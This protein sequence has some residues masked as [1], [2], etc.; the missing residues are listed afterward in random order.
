MK[1][2]FLMA[3]CALCSTGIWADTAVLSWNMGADGAAASGANSITG[4]AGCDAEGFT[5]A[6]TGNTGKN[7]SNGNGSISYNGK[8]Y[9][10]LKNSNGAQNTITLP[11]G[12]Y[13]SKVEFHVVSNADASGVLSE[14][15]GASCSDVV[16]SL[17]DYANP[18]LISKTLS[19]PVNSFTFTFSTKQV[20][21]IAV[22]TYSGSVTPTCANPTIQFGSWDKTENGFPVTITNNEQG[23]TLTYA[24][25]EGEFQAYTTSFFVGSEVV[26]KA[27][28]SKAD[29]NDSEVVTATAPAHAEGD[30]EATFAWLVGNE[31]S[32]TITS[33]KADCVNKTKVSTGSGLTVDTKSDYAANNGNTM[34]TYVPA[35]SNAGN[36][37][38]VMIEYSIA[39]AKGTT[40]QL[41]A[42]KYDALKDG[43][44][45]ASFSWSYT[46]DG[47]ESD[48]AVVS[49]DDLLR[50]NNVSGT[51]ALR[52]EE[53][54]T[55]AAGKNVTVRFY[56]SGFGNTKKFALSNIE[57]VGTI[58]GEPVLRTFQDFKIEFRDNPY[59]VILPESGTLP[60][61][62]EV[63]GTTYNGG[64][65]GIQGG[66]ITVPVDGA[67]LF[68][69]G[70]C[71]FSKDVI[72]VKKD[73]E[74]FTTISNNA[75]CGEQKP[76][77]NQF[78]TWKYNSE[79]AATLTFSIPG[80]VYIPYFFAEKAEYVAQVEVTYYDADGHTIIGKQNIE[81]GAALAFAYTA[82]D[83]TV[84]EGQ[85]FRGWFSSTEL[86]A[87]KIKAGTKVN[88][89]L[90]LYA[91][92]TDI[93]V[94]TVGSVFE[95][96][97]R[98][99]YFYPEDHELFSMTNSS[100]KDAQHGWSFGANGTI[101]LEVA[102]NAVI[103]FNLCQYGNASE[104]SCTDGSANPVGEAI[105]LPVASDGNTG[106][107]RYIGDATTLTFTLSN[108]GYVHSVKVYNVDNVP[109]ENEA[110]FFVLGAGDGAGLLLMLETAKD[111]DK[112]FLPN[113]TYDL[114]AIT[115]TEINAGI[116]LIGESM[117]GVLIVN[118]P[119]TAGMNNSETLHL[120]A[121]G[122]YLQDLAVRCD[123]AYEGSVA[124]GGVGIAI[125][126]RGDKNIYKHVDLQGNQDT[127]LS[128]GA[129]NQR[130]YFEDGR[131]EGTVDYI[132]GGGNIW[133]ENILFFNNDRAN[134]DVI[135][136]PATSAETVYGYVVSNCTVDGAAGQDG[137]WNMARGWKAAAA[138][139]WLN[140][141]C[142]IAPSAKGYTNMGAGLQVRFHEYNTHLE[143]GT[144]IT[145][146]NL[147]GLGYAENSDAIYLE[148]EGV[149]TYDNVIKGDDNWDAKAIAAQVKADAEAIDAD[150]AY[151][152][153]DEGVFVAI[154]KGS[155]L[156]ADYKGKTI[157]QANARGGFGEAVAYNPIGT[158]IGAISNQQSAVSVQKVMRD[159]QLIIIRDGQK[160]NAAG[161]ELR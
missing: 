103:K 66:T 134:A 116:S 130:C 31:A 92:V 36:V 127:Y 43:T 5:I 4:A 82:E 141:T 119:Q 155:Q 11:E 39:M 160:Y 123:V 159:G 89:D 78:V 10:T 150:A 75:S 23:A 99:A 152:V 63:D 106:V 38:D 110:G 94:A 101:A 28:A 41:S 32:A 33:A 71:Q 27:K 35:T 136:A 138:V 77:Y 109:T 153:E 102:G 56:V 100:Y 64:Q 60:T 158:A 144:V 45:N 3:L 80:N 29:Y 95:Y 74:D 22:V 53:A 30:A 97:L 69:I 42:V 91:R 76:N 124:S 115:L 34:V 40:F 128:S 17:K 88:E 48:I 73:G 50:N 98:Q 6:I 72:T 70:A 19:T 83:V 126:D 37:A 129:A 2:L 24:V 58:S 25:G 107:F 117:E 93:E 132:C 8:T 67:V 154:V 131:I 61:G 111:G 151:L 1:K 18:T 145:G 149:Y 59:T 118:H 13:A 157:R 47:T 125:Q 44:D 142:K 146:H 113:G 137:N 57:I 120:R 147:E 90:K 135:F 122:I 52:H 133:F 104:L 16:S 139:T 156:S 68:T 86:T 143:D 7:W 21:F 140:T 9:Q 161:F 84:G 112:I 87:V 51:P 14:F 12:K 20:C 96:D 79:E 26:V 55:A 85:A 49:K 148:N 121:G 81:N 62:V 15:N 108:G 105:T 54:I 114:G 46:V 65:H